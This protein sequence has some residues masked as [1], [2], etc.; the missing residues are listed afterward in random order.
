MSQTAR[1][2]DERGYALLTV[3]LLAALMMGVAVAYFSWIS[4]NGEFTA[5][6]EL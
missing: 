2:R 1:S 3:L 4:R 6:T 5:S